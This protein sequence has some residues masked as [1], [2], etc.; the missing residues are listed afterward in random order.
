[1]SIWALSDLHLSFSAPSKDMAFFGPSWEDYAAKIEKHWLS[2]VQKDDLV[3]IPGD[4]SWAMTLEEALTDLLW[5]D[6]LPGTKLLL[7]GNHDYWWASNKK[8]QE[9]LPSSLFFIHNNVFQWNN[10]TIGGARLWDTDEYDFLPYIVMQ[11]NPRARKDKVEDPEQGKKIF[12]K[13]LER[14]KE[15]LKQLR[16]DASLR[17]ALTH[18]PPIGSDLKPS[19]AS[20]I[21]KEYK[22]DVCVFGHLHNVRKGSL[23]FGSAE[24]TKYV[25]ASCDYLD[26]HPI[27]IA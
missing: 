11:E 18:Y 21:L 14:L 8:M 10:V 2:C 4:I 23:P 12:A 6:R 24:G 7:K 25:F 16:P 26:F 22:V 9:K 3:L 15:S 27:F 1:M 19:K 5:I 20:M 13:E 17:I